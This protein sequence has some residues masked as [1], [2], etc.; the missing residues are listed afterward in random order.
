MVITGFPCLFAGVMQLYLMVVFGPVFACMLARY[1]WP[2]AAGDPSERLV[3]LS[4]LL[5]GAQ[6]KSR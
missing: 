2:G 3:Q 5:A 4:T 1:W 6:V